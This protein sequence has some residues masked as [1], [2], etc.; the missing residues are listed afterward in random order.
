MHPST[1]YLLTQLHLEKVSRNLVGK[2]QEKDWSSFAA[3]KAAF[4]H[5]Y[6]INFEPKNHETGLHRRDLILACVPFWEKNP[7]PEY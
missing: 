6:G 2:W 4:A 7:N 5:K 3:L 1:K